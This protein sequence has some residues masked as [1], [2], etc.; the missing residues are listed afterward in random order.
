MM[1]TT[2]NQSIELHLLLEAIFLKYGFDFRHYSKDSIRR[3]TGNRLAE[4]HLANL[5]ELTHKVLYDA[6]MFETLLLDLSINV[7]EMFRDPVFFKSLRNS[8]LPA[9]GRLPFIKVWHA[10]CATGEEVYSTAIIL[11]EEGLYARARLFATDFN[12]VVLRRAKEGI[13]PIDRIK[14]YTANYQKAGGRESFADYYSARYDSAVMRRA[15]KKNL[16]F[17]SH[18]LATDGVF[19][20]MDMVMC[21]N[22]LIYFERDLQ[23]RALRL[24]R[25][26]LAS[27][28]FLC[29]GSKESLQFSDCADDFDMF[30]PHQKIYRKK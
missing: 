25:D 5:S 12:Q 30:E 7:T 14:T 18:D 28:G 1:K 13:F 17:A 4:W 9:L 21:R 29:L 26:S 20:D 16:I 2:D 3:R 10:G 6:R 8:V 24:F 27:G 11:Q 19:G 22:V 23:N 15:L